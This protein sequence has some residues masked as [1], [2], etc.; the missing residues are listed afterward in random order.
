MPKS[1]VSGTT[2]FDKPYSAKNAAKAT[3]SGIRKINERV[4]ADGRALI[5]TTEDLDKYNW[6]D[7]PTGSLLVN[8][9]T[10]VIQAKLKNVLIP[11][12]TEEK[13]VL[14]NAKIDDKGNVV[15]SNTNE[16]LLKADKTPLMSSDIKIDSESNWV[17]C[18]IK[19]DG[20]ICISKDAI[21]ETEIF[22][23]VNPVADSN[24][25][26]EYVNS[27]GEHR[28]MP[29]TEDGYYTFKLEKGSYPVGRNLLQVY[30]DGVLLRTAKDNGLVELDNRRFA[31]TD[32]LETGHEIIAKYNRV[33]RIGN[34]Y[35]RM[36]IS[37]EAPED[38][39]TGDFWLDYDG[40]LSDAD[41]LGE[42]IEN[43]GTVNWDKITGRPSTLAGYG[44]TD[45]VSMKGH[46]HRTSDISN[47]PSSLPANGGNADTIDGH[48]VGTGIGQIP[49]IN[50]NG[51]I[52]AGVMPVRDIL[53]AVYPVGSIIECTN[54]V[55]PGTSYGLKW[56]LYGQ[57]RMVVGYGG[58][59][60]KSG[61]TGGEAEHALTVDELP[62]HNHTAETTGAHFHGTWGEHPDVE[63][64]PPFG[65]YNDCRNA[66]GSNGGWDTDNSIYKTSTDGDHTHAISNTGKN[67][68][69]NNMPPYIVVY[70]YVRTA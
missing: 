15:D 61:T 70:R 4:V 34:P 28:H 55:C 58:A 41:L 25:T 66:A 68:P 12:N 35:P 9:K 27:A 39:E 21:V 51:N 46:M 14:Y 22:T 59:Y 18:G 5:I 13:A 56:E 62:A 6:K 65:K 26:F 43:N 44:I 37:S 33:I 52:P 47:F 20:T 30:I 60:N 8:N 45:S 29:V 42:N 23:V 36:F 17:P 31:V 57:G 64:P 53:D 54:G 16:P 2:F 11:Y 10:G 7:I 1:D 63:P 50:S 40:T 49:F 3:G 24:G 69:H 48:G 32:K 19:N 67:K 38:A